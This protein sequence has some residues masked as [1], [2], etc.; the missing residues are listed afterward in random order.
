M[1]PSKLDIDVLDELRAEFGVDILVEL[2][3]MAEASA[4]NELDEL[5]RQIDSGSRLKTR[6]IAHSL[7]GILGQYGAMEAARR[8]R[9]TQHAGDDEIFEQAACLVQAGRE[10]LEELRRYADEAEPIKTRVA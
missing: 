1:T 2:L 6:R 9:E 7:V 4:E 8:A 10:A 3:R 5:S